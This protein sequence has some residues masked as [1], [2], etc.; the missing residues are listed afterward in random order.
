MSNS[1]GKQVQRI[2]DEHKNFLSKF[3]KDR[4]LY[5]DFEKFKKYRIIELQKITKF[6][7]KFNIEMNN[8]VYIKKSLT[9]L[10]FKKDIKKI[11]FNL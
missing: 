2:Y 3:D 4:I 7:D 9:N 5:I 6:F 8:K 11:K 10:K 1:V